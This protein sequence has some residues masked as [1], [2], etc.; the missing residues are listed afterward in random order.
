MRTAAKEGLKLGLI[1]PITLWPFPTT[2]IRKRADEG[3]AFLVVEMSAGQMV[4]DVRL[5][6]EGRSPVGFIGRAGGGSPEPVEVINKAREML[7]AHESNV[8]RA[9]RG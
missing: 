4:E 7:A 3:R 2:I 5:A 8:R 6:V 1:R 9:G